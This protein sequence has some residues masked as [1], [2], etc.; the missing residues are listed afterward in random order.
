MSSTRN[1][2]CNRRAS[3]AYDLSLPGKPT[4][5]VGIG[6]Y[7]DGRVGELFVTTR[8]I[9]S[10]FDAECADAAVMVSIALQ[11][12]IT[13][14]Q[15]YHSLHRTPEGEPVSVMGHILRGLIEG[16]E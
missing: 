7:D 11:H 5:T 2:L 13:P 14:Q 3:E 12:G 16:D 10:A 9:G 15:L 6:Y 1:P 4:I 8:K